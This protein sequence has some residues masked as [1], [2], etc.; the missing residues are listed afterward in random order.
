[1]LKK[2]KMLM[3]NNCQNNL[4]VKLTTCL[5]TDEKLSHNRQNSDNLMAAMPLS[6]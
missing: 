4:Q 6:T 5:K 1:M 3:H 2:N